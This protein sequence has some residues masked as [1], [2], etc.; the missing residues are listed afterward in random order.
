MLLLAVTILLHPAQTDNIIAL[1][2]ILITR[3]LNFCI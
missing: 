3:M 2:A 1:N